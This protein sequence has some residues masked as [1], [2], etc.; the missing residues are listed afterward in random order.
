M[1]TTM[2]HFQKRFIRILRWSEKYTKTDMVYLFKSGAWINLGSICVSLFS[3]VLYIA[4]ARFLP[5]EV[6]G[7]YQYLLSV[8]VIVS[9]F[10]LTGMNTAVTRAVARGF[11]GMVRKSIWVQLRWGI[12]PFLGAWAASAY[13]FLHG[14]QQLGWGLLLIGIFVPINGALNTYGAL[15]GGRRDFQGSFLLNLLCN[16]LYYPALIIAAFFSKVACV[17]LAANVLSQFVGL[18]IAYRLARRMYRPNDHVDHETIPYGKH[19]SLMNIFGT[20]TGQVDNILAFH[21][22]GPAALAL[23]SYATALPERLANLTKFIPSA[24]FPKFATQSRAEVRRTIAPKLLWAAGASAIMTL[25]YVAFAH[26]FFAIFF[27]AYIAA[28]PYSMVYSLIIIPWATGIFVSALSATRSVRALYV[29][30]GVVPVVQLAL[31]FAG[32]LLLGLWGLILAKLVVAFVQLFFGAYLFFSD[33]S[34]E[35]QSATSVTRT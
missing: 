33:D 34:P 31:Q 24:A 12:I 26:I 30:N 28:V 13:Y 16:T 5:K 3:F 19:L 4:F 27:P 1:Y 35:H 20:I 2:Q 9:A 6:Y 18:F 23:Y 25:V 10:T 32:I 22:L 14:N 8:S 15:P 11:D 7:T 29:F 21:Y 17:L